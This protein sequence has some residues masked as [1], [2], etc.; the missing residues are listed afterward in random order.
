[1]L[2]TGLVGAGDV[3]DP[4]RTDGVAASHPSVQ[5]AAHP[6]QSHTEGVKA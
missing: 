4:N 1:M 2:W 5:T 6:K 3:I